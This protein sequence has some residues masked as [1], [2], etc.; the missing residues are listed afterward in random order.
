MFYK[1]LFDGGPVGG[2]G[3]RQGRQCNRSWPRQRGAAALLTKRQEC[4]HRVHGDGRTAT[5]VDHAQEALARHIRKTLGFKWLVNKSVQSL[6]NPRDATLDGD[7]SASREY[8]ASGERI[9]VLGRVQ[10]V[11]PL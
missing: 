1:P 11:G 2:R 3:T 9:R 6:C 10:T 8:E 7:Y 4:V 5:V